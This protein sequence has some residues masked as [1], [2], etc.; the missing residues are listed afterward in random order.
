[1]EREQQRGLLPWHLLWPKSGG[2]RAGGLET[3]RLR[4][5]PEAPSSTSCLILGRFLH[6]VPPKRG[7]PQGFK[8]GLPHLSPPAP[9][10]L[11]YTASPNP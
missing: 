6:L 8:T 7:D 9:T 10:F 3:T 2:E 1:M 5:H 11:A 4:A